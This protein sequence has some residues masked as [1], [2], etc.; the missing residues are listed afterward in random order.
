MVFSSRTKRYVRRFLRSRS[1]NI[2]IISVLMMPVIVGF[3]ALAAESS[4]WYSRH[5]NIQ[6]A[7]DI[8]AYDGAIT[9]ARGGDDAEVVAAAKAGAITNGWRS[10]LGTITVEQFGPFVDVLL[11]ENQ[12]RSFS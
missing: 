4:Y 6:D 12:E 2:A 1:G 9:L 7:A 5:R 10:N 11:V 3:C 8:A